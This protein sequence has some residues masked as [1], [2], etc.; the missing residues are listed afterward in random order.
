MSTSMTFSELYRRI[1]N[2][3]QAVNGRQH[4]ALSVEATYNE[5]LDVGAPPR[6]R[7]DYL[8]VILPQTAD[9]TPVAIENQFRLT[10]AGT[11]DAI[12]SAFTD[13]VLPALRGCCGHEA[14]DAPID[15][16]LELVDVCGQGQVVEAS[17]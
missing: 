6:E 13:K 11:T 5:S 9:G 1:R 4:F 15:A 3:I 10:R 7:I 16:R 12:W 2:E 14:T 17:A 8:L